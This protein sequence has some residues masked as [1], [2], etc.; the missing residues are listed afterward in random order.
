MDIIA[1]EHVDNCYTWE[2]GEVIGKVIR[3]GFE[4]GEHVTISFR[5]VRDVPSSF[6]NAAFISLLDAYPYEFITA[7]LSIIDVTKQIS[8][9]ITRRF[10]FERNRESASPE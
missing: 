7:N 1:L 9:M 6:V 5:G 10:D 4:R 3:V 8:T 2:A